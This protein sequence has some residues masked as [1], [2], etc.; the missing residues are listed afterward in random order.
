MRVPG[1]YAASP[2]ACV[3]CGAHKSVTDSHAR[4]QQLLPAVERHRQAG[5]RAM[6]AGAYLNLALCRGSFPISGCML[7]TRQDPCFCSQ[8]VVAYGKQP[9][10]SPCPQPKPPAPPPPPL[11][12]NPCI[13][14]GHTIPVEHHVDAMI[15]QDSDPS[16]NHTWTNF[17][18]SRAA[19]SFLLLS[20]LGAGSP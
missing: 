4:R 8:T 13:R 10:A 5:P 9:P 18:V 16:I 3:L 1:R 7:C 14:F 20:A 12:Q 17:K 11:A 6:P 19:N 15:V 2:A